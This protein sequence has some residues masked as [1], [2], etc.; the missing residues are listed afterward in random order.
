MQ[1]VMFSQI[2]EKTDYSI[3]INLQEEVRQKNIPRLL[4]NLTVLNSLGNIISMNDYLQ[5]VKKSNSCMLIDEKYLEHKHKG[6][7]NIQ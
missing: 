3:I 7:T 6:Y 2:T 4:S 1:N 5:S